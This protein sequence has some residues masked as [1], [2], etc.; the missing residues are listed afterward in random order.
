MPGHLD[1]ARAAR[2]MAAEGLDALLLT[3]PESVRYAAGAGPGLAASWRRGITAA[4]LVPADPAR[5]L[6]AVVGDL[7]APGFA[8]AS[9]IP[10]LRTHPIWVDTAAV[11]PGADPLAALAALTPRPRPGTFDPDAVPRLLRDLLAARGLTGGTVGFERDILPA[12]DSDRLAAALDGGARFRDG[13]GM[14]RRLRAVKS[15][16]EIALLERG[17]RL[18]AAG[19]SAA[20]AALRPG[21][22]AAD[23]TRLW[24]DAVTEAAAR[25]PGPAPDDTWAYV[26]VGPHGFGPGRAAEPGDLIKM[27][28]GC[29]LSGYSS[30]GAR[31]FSLG[32]AGP[33]ERR[34][35]AALLAGFE[36]GFP[37]L[38]PGT[39]L[40]DVHH[41][42]T[43][44]VRAECLR[45]YSRGHFGH[46]LGAG[47]WSE[48]WPFI[49]G[50]C[51][52]VLEAGTV[53]AFETPYYVDGLGAFM[54][55]DQV[56]VTPDGPRPMIDLPRDLVAIG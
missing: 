31:T 32:P 17:S 51:H 41:A 9:G 6:G 11:P 40:P 52:H 47:A 48:E 44:A 1:R 22:D 29:V 27:D 23:V 26:T 28:M 42:V 24:R 56:L 19:M 20:S 3:A 16:A 4:V 12:N 49:A 50:D 46:G 10:D 7:E 55:E 18:A 45:G 15:P 8:A 54:I 5:P 39:A 38:R 25:T 30:D 14:L 13:S 53:L 35:H 21:L 2:L 33:A 34:V 36:T 43:R 37:L